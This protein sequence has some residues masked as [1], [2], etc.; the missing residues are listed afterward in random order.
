[1]KTLRATIAYCEREL[2]S[3]DV[4]DEPEPDREPPEEYDEEEWAD[5]VDDCEAPARA[6]LTTKEINGSRYYYW[7]WSEDGSTKSEYIAPVNPKR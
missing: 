1:M 3:D 6:T 2:E 4:D 5:A 7:Q